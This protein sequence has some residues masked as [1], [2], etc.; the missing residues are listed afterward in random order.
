M[1][2]MNP[3]ARDIHDALIALVGTDRLSTSVAQLE[4]HSHD[5]SDHPPSLGDIVVWPETTE[6]VSAILTAANHHRVPIVGWGAGTGVEGHAI[7]VHGGVVIDFARMNQIVAVLPEDFQAIVQ[8]GVL[9]L[10]LEKNLSQHGL[11][12]PPD[13]GANA[14]IG[15]MIANNAGG[16]RALRYGSTSVN[17]LALEVVMADGTVVRTGSRSVKLSSG[18]DLTHLIVGSEGTLGLVTEA[19]LKLV[20]VP[21]HSRTVLVAFASVADA[22]G[23]V[24][25]IMGYGLGP[26]ALELIDADHMSWMN[27][28]EGTDFVVAPSLM[29]EFSG[30][31]LPAVSSQMELAAQICVEA[32]ATGITQGSGMDYRAGLWR[33]R[34]GSRERLHRRFPGEEWS[35][36]DVSVPISRF[37]EL[38]MFAVSR[39]TELGLDG[40]TVGHAGDGNLHF[41]VHFDPKDDDH[42]RRTELHAQDLVMKAIELGGTC[43]GE[44]GIG[45]GKRK[46]LVAEHGEP[47]IDLMRILKRAMDPNGILNPGKVLP[48][49]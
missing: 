45:I 33:L 8:P 10:D 23:A 38:V 22:A 26:A 42:R 48:D 41:G 32:G 20:P 25:A 44:H 36:S 49:A 13:P 24:H 17:V 16:I 39:A 2:R 29:I 15:G 28:E 12:F 31:D 11:F 14:S 18:Y 27:E 7:P 35:T 19:T 30:T 34:H 47:A 6:E 3:P 4:L 9:R 1:P 5:E 40:R 46:Y 37:A 43:S 21:E